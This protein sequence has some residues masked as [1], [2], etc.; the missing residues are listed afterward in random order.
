MAN[1]CAK[2]QSARVT[3][4]I[5]T[6]VA[7]YGVVIGAGTCGRVHGITLRAAATGESTESVDS[8]AAVRAPIV[9]M[10]SRK[11]GWSEGAQE[12]ETVK[13]MPEQEQPPVVSRNSGTKR[14][15]DVC[16]RWAW[17]E[18]T[19]WTRPMLETLE[20]GVKGGKWFALID[21]VSRTTTLQRAWEGVK[22]NG[23]SAGVDGTTVERFERNCESRL[24]AVKEHLM[25]RDYRPEPV[26]RV[27]IEKSGGGQRPLGIP[28]VRDRVVQNALR[29]VIEPIFEKEFATHSY[30]FRPGRGC[31]DALR[32]VDALLQAG[33]DWVVD[34][35]LKSYF[36]SIPHEKLMALVE[37][38]ICDGGVLA[39]ILSF[40]KQGVME[41]MKHYEAGESGTPQ[42]AVM[43]PLLAN[44]YL[45]PLDHLMAGAGFEMVRY[46]D[47]FV[48]LCRER[49]SAE[50]A[51]ATIK[52]WVEQAGLTLHPEK[53]RLVDTRERGGFDFLG[54]HFERG[55]KWPRKK[56]V[57]KLRE[58]M[59]EVTPRNSGKP[60][61]RIIQ[62]LNATMRGWYEYFKH[63]T[64]HAMKEADQWV[65][66]RIRGILRRR[67]KRAGYVSRY[68][69]PRYPN[70]LLAKLGLFSLKQ[71]HATEIQSQKSSHSPTGEPDAG[72]P[73]VRFGGR[74][75]E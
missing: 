46:A 70:T 37:E 62:Q 51:L 8:A 49:E 75:G 36:D 29:M 56:S 32:R 27:W 6:S 11:A 48:V 24:L 12:G 40:L 61:G 60:I 67:T 52:Q 15:G 53:T 55:R 23:G 64:A 28:T 16:A 71:A 21:K 43:S 69:L 5:E 33:H 68:D 20:R 39:L 63:S 34:A 26:R 45:N 25:A 4:R 65:R 42:G 41:Q 13:D 2:A 38:R 10:K 3:E 19:V 1:L 35:D 22:S 47:D 7:G 44:I 54:Y 18:E 74:G 72:N 31:K 59:R 66:Q 14:G 73:P 30:G 50:Q 17:T 57:Q 58:R 9:A